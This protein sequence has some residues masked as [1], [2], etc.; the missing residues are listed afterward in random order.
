MSDTPV[1]VVFYRYEWCWLLSAKRR[2]FE[3]MTRVIDVIM[4]TSTG[5]TTANDDDDDD[6]SF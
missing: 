3:R 6:D 1:A 2:D 5:T 4:S